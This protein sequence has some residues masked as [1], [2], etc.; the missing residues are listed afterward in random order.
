MNASIELVAE[1]GHQVTGISVSE[2]KRI[3]VNFPRW[4]E[5]NE[6][7]FAELAAGGQL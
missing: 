3:F 6:I 2:D 7:S 5:D 4:T 1:F